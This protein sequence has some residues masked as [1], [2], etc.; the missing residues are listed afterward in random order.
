MIQVL[1]L[2]NTVQRGVFRDDLLRMS[3]DLIYQEAKEGQIPN[4]EWGH[5]VK[6]LVQLGEAIRVGEILWSL[7]S[8]ETFIL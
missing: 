2:I 8:D 5:F 6:V 7:V 3:V 4:E 1:Q